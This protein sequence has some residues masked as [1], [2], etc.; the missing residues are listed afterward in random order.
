MGTNLRHHPH[1]RF[2]LRLSSL[3]SCAAVQVARRNQ[4]K[5]F[6]IQVEKEQSM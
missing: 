4:P 2:V 6:T 1:R 3:V 5:M